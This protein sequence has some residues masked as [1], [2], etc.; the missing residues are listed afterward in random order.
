MSRKMRYLPLLLLLISCSFPFG[1]GTFSSSDPEEAFEEAT[2]DEQTILALV[3][4]LRSSGCRCGRSTM[5]PTDSL[6]SNDRLR[7]AAQKHAVDM[8]QNQ[9]FKHR[10]S[11]G[12]RVA[13]RAE[14]AGYLW[15]SIGENLSLNYTDARGA[16]ESWR[17]SPEH[18]KNMM[19]DHFE[20]MGLAKVGPYWVQTLGSRSN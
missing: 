5:P 14:Q 1:E 4:A 6:R 13:D 17:K 3:N 10:G 11:D 19:A 2:P 20:D 16:F 12:S 8:Y 15:K 7:A 9:F 18:C